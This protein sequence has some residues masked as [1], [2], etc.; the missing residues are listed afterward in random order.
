M[1]LCLSFVTFALCSGCATSL[2]THPT[3]THLPV[4]SFVPDIALTALARG[5]LRVRNGCV[6]LVGAD[7]GS[8]TL[9]IWPKDSRLISQGR[10][11][12]IMVGGSDQRLKVG[13]R[14]QLGGGTSDSVDYEQLAVPLPAGC[15]GPYFHAN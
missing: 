4:R 11:Q 6:R 13:T 9:V 15:G 3:V 2:L 10:G 5:N 7:G 1:K 12:V 14:V 8:G